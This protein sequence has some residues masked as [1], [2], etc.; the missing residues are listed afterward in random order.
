MCFVLWISLSLIAIKPLLAIVVSASGGCVVAVVVGGGGVLGNGICIGIGWGGG[1]GIGGADVWM[2]EMVLI[3]QWMPL[4][5]TNG[6]HSIVAHLKYLI[7]LFAIVI[8]VLFVVQHK[9]FTCY[10]FLTHLT[11]F[12]EFLIS[13]FAHCIYFV[14]LFAAALKKCTIIIERQR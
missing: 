10:K 1:G 5:A 14:D 7:L 3:A 9:Y 8:T 12:M 11:F 4:G 13:I 6:R 2:G